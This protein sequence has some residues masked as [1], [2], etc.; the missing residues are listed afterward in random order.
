MRK[1]MLLAVLI[2]VLVV[3]ALALAERR[4]NNLVEIS[5]NQAEPL[6]ATGVTLSNLN[7]NWDANGV[8]SMHYR[9]TPRHGLVTYADMF[10]VNEGK[11]LYK[12]S[13]HRKL[14]IDLHHHLADD[15]FEDTVYF[16]PAVAPFTMD[17]GEIWWIIK[18]NDGGDA[19]MAAIIWNMKTN[20]ATWKPYQ[21]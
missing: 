20:Q 19:K 1:R 12:R 15:H 4:E 7:I 9:V 18:Y 21:P 6:K 17:A 11:V 3:A 2:G 14:N 16:I 8:K 5:F 13:E 10:V